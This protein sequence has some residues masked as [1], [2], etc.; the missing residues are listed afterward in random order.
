LNPD[1]NGRVLGP[2]PPG[3]YSATM[4]AAAAKTVAKNV[5]LAIKGGKTN[6]LN[7][8]FTPDGIVSG[9][10]TTALKAEDRP[11]GMPADRY[12]PADNKITVQTII[13]SGAG[14]R[15]VLHPLKGEN[16]DYID[17]IISHDDFCHNGSFFFFGLPAGGYEL[18]IHAQGYQPLTQKY[19]VIPG[20]QE[21]QRVTELTVK[22]Q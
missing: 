1:D 7:F 2:F 9:Y 22:K 13:L 6:D 16:I 11:A 19:S 20:R 18:V 5:P 14:I 3:K 17:Y 10:V 21:E 8:V 15:R 4:I 12:L